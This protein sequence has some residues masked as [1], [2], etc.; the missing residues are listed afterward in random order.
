MRPYDSGLLRKENGR[1]NASTESI[2]VGASVNT[3]LERWCKW[4]AH[5]TTGLKAEEKSVCLWAIL[6]MLQAQ[7]LPVST[8]MKAQYLLLTVL[9]VI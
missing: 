4:M 3:I 2:G 1:N 7:D 8:D 9:N 5:I 6:T